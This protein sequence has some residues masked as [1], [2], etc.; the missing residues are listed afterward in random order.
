MTSKIEAALE[1]GDLVSATVACDELSHELSEQ[2][3]F[4][5]AIEALSN[6][7]TFLRTIGDNHA[8][9]GYVESLTL[10]VYSE[11]AW[12]LVPSPE[13]IAI[14]QEAVAVIKAGRC[15]PMDLAEVL[16]LVADVTIVSGDL[17]QA[18]EASLEA[19][20]AA[21]AVCLHQLSQQ[22]EQ[23]MAH[24]FRYEGQTEEADQW[25]ARASG[26]LREFI[27]GHVHLWDIRPTG[28]GRMEPVPQNERHGP[29]YQPVD[30]E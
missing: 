10:H 28:D 17:D 13:A 20:K 11:L 1:S 14:A 3:D 8:H 5:G 12:L 2:E 29:P 30:P 15:H 24:R 4:E 27:P 6:G 7:V 18:I 21:E 22:V 25:A 16:T 19:V 9:D 23:S 26:R